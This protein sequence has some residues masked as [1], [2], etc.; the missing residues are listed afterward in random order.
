MM[1]DNSFSSH[2]VLFSL[3][4]AYYDIPFVVHTTMSSLLYIYYDVSV[5]L[6]TITLSFTHTFIL[7]LFACLIGGGVCP[8]CVYCVLHSVSDQGTSLFCL[9]DY[10]MVVVCREPL[11]QKVGNDIYTF[12]SCFLNILRYPTN[13]CNNKQV[14]LSL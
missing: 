1:I 9:F 12:V 3:S 13:H 5:S 11:N 7:Y 6:A 14:L 4:F 10:I 2:N 8:M